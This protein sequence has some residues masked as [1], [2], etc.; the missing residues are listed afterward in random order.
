MLYLPRRSSGY[1]VDCPVVATKW[2]S[3]SLSLPF[4]FSFSL[5]VSGEREHALTH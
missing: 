5:R 2:R 1:F 3:S 4:L